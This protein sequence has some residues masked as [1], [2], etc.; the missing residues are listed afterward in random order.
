[1]TK[2]DAA[3]S[4]FPDIAKLI[5][6]FKV[7]GLDVSRI[8]E[9][10]RKNIEALTQANQAAYEGMQDLA[11]RQ[12]EILRET[13]SEWQ[14]AMTDAANRE[15]TNAAQR[16]EAAEKTFGKAFGNMRELA[17]MAAKAQTQAWE[18]IQKRFQENLADLRNLLLPPK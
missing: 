15:S 5:E 4:P 9:T 2:T 8:V 18:M 16:A 1:M 17:E 10:Q 12:M 14:A 3:K 11:K 7:P 13:V 6:Q